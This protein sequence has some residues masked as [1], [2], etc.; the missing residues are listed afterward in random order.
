MKL[1]QPIKIAPEIVTGDE[2][3]YTI[4]GKRGNGKTTFSKALIKKF[5]DEQN[6]VII[7]FDVLNEYKGDYLF[8]SLSSFFAYIKVNGLHNKLSY[9]CSFDNQDDYSDLITFVSQLEN[10]FLVFEEISNFCSSYSIDENLA[11]IAKYGRHNNL[12]YLAIARRPAEI[13]NLILSQSHYII[14]F[15]QILKPDID[16]L[17]FFGFS[18]S[19]RELEKFKYSWVEV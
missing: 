5:A 13:N 12:N 17:M 7:I 2:V 4:L 15:R 1:F 14:T 16:R 18:E 3:N 6:K 9:V 10:V 19:I 11:N 8:T